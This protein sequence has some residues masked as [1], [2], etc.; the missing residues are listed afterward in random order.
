MTYLPD[1]TKPGP[2]SYW[3]GGGFA[4]TPS[5]PFHK[6]WCSRTTYNKWTTTY[7]VYIQHVQLQSLIYPLVTLTGLWKLTIFKIFP[8][9][10]HYKLPFSIAVLNYQRVDIESELNDNCRSKSHLVSRYPLPL[11]QCQHAL[12]QLGV[13]PAKGTSNLENQQRSHHLWL[14]F[15]GCRHSC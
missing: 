1:V 4:S 13:L 2:A 15:D 3:V 8:W 10:T 11:T 6:V 12:A 14:E 9:Q 5:W 7:I